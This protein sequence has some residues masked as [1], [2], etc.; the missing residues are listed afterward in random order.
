MSR[1]FLMQQ[2]HSFIAVKILTLVTHQLQQKHA[3]C[4]KMRGHGSFVYLKHRQV[5][6]NKR[7]TFFPPN[8]YVPFHLSISLSQS[9]GNGSLGPLKICSRIPSIGLSTVG[10]TDIIFGVVQC[11]LPFACQE[12]ITSKILFH[13]LYK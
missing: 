4:T 13:S 1:N 5:S 2:T 12:H 8:F 7:Y 3:C 10:S 6:P 9:V 11:P